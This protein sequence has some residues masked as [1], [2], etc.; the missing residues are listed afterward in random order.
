M[1][2]GWPERLGDRT[3][4]TDQDLRAELAAEQR[5][6]GLRDP[7]VASM[8]AVEQRRR[9]VAAVAVVDTLGLV[10]AML[11]TIGVIDL[12]DDGLIGART[13]RDASIGFAVCMVLYAFDKERHLRRFVEE[14]DALVALDGE[15]AG[16]LL[17]SGLLL[18]AATAVHSSLELDTVLAEVVDHGQAL[19][20]SSRAVLFLAEEHEPMQA[21]VDR[22]GVA[23]QERATVAMV[24]ESGSVVVATTV[25]VTRIGVPVTADGELLGVL[26]LVDTPGGALL[27]DLRTLL[28][29]YGAIAGRALANARRYEAAMFLIDT[30]I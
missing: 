3:V 21:A 20:G 22:D 15:V 4:R 13:A 24:V 1:S 14:R 17:A 10:V 9:Q 18:D 19:A 5:R 7:G 25:D 11:M 28:T 16:H 8:A 30:A 27:D 26:V 12:G 6:A 23:E 29:A 2:H